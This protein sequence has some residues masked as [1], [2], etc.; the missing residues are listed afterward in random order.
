MAAPLLRRFEITVCKDKSAQDSAQVP[1]AATVDVY[2]Q[3]ATVRTAFNFPSI[4]A[5]PVS[6]EVYDTGRIQV[7]DALRVSQGAFVGGVLTVDSIPDGSHLM[8]L[9]DAVVS[10]SAGDRLVPTSDRP[11]VYQNPLGTGS[12]LHY[13]MSDATTGRASGYIAEGRYDFRVSGTGFDDRMYR[14]AHGGVINS[15]GRA[16]NALDFPS[17]QAAVD[18][19]GADGGTVV[20]PRGTYNAETLPAYDGHLVLPAQEKPIHLQGEGPGLTLLETSDGNADMLVVQSR[21]SKI[22]GITFDG[23]EQ[24]GVSQGG[25][26]GIVVG[27]L[28]PAAPRILSE[29]TIEGCEVRETASWG[30]DLISDTTSEDPTEH[31]LSIWTECVRLRIVAPRADGGIRIGPGNTT[32]YFKNCSVVGFTGH[33]ALVEP[34]SGITFDGCTFEDSQD[35][36]ALTPYVR[37]RGFVVKLVNCWFE[38]HSQP[39]SGEFNYFIVIGD[40]VHFA[41]N[42]SIDTCFFAQ[43]QARSG[44][45]VSVGGGSKAVSIVAPRLGI[46]DSVPGG[47]PPESTAD[48]LIGGFAEV[49]MLEGMIATASD[50]FGFDVEEATTSRCYSL[51]QDRVRVPRLSAS[52][53]DALHAPRSG[54][55]LVNRTSGR[56]EVYTST[57]REVAT[58]GKQPRIQFVPA[59]LWTQ[60]NGTAMGLSGKGTSLE[61]MVSYSFVD[62]PSTGPQAVGTTVAI[63]VDY[64]VGTPVPVSVLWAPAANAA[65][66]YDRTWVGRV[67]VLKVV[68]G[69]LFDA[70]AD[71]VLQGTFTYYGSE[72][73]SGLPDSGKKVVL[74]AW[75]EAIP[76]DLVEAGGL[77]RFVFDRLTTDSE[78][79]FPQAVEFFGIALGIR[80]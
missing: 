61:K 43:Q 2:R 46:P 78:D 11:T 10:A 8:V 24:D 57:W 66:G 30:L 71:T 22:S 69:V 56:L 26:R 55:L 37:I 67:Q 4:L 73:P 42:V 33:G 72:T 44:H 6:V 49:I 21:K 18:F 9:N 35:P 51:A 54:D 38:H 76:A 63:P 1:A 3:G 79:D 59:S 65:V 62:A 32:A 45:L 70:A 34:A 80:S 39:A 27:T 41:N 58:V 28:G 15:S 13:T 12:G 5:D 29:V 64:E 75:E 20:I 48:I 17:L 77:L 31:S 53:R 52:H 14:D 40:S 50:Y 36:V 19:L 25:G 16:V 7:G 47:A 23:S 60:I 68:D 74:Q